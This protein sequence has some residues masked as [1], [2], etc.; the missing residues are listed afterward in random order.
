VR[1]IKLETKTVECDIFQI[2]IKLTAKEGK[3]LI[4]IPKEIIK[5][6][7]RRMIEGLT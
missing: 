4:T 6:V 7:V 5:A 3:S 2:K 1:N